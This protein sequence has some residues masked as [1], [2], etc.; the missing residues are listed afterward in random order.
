[1]PKIQVYMK[2][3]L[4]TAY[5]ETAFNIATL[6]LRLACGILICIYYG[7]DKMKNFSHLQYVFP[8][9]VPV[10]GHRWSLVLVIFAE[11]FCSLLLVLGLFTRFAALVLVISMGVALFLVHKGH[12]PF[13]NGSV[14]EQ[15]YLYF[16]AFV[17]ILMIGPGRISIDG[18]MGK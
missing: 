13:V 5:S 12:V 10:L 8:D 16:A 9:P 18:A 1:M 7:L 17:A 2:R 6:A 11:V 15:V 14:H 4:S 3:F